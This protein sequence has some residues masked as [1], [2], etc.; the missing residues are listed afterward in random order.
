MSQKARRRL[1]E[2]PAEALVPFET[3]Q[4]GDA[5]ATLLETGRLGGGLAYGDRDETWRGAYDWM[6]ERMA[7]AIA[8]FSGEYPVWGWPRAIR[9]TSRELRWKEGLWRIRALVPRGRLLP[10][11][12]ALWHHPLNGWSIDRDEDAMA[13][14]WHAPPAAKMETWGAVLQI[15]GRDPELAAFLGEP[16]IVQLCLDGLLLDEVYDT[17]PISRFRR[18]VPG[19]R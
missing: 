10:S 14:N 2:A 8:G 15:A 17:V 13:R 4:D 7:G 16:E 3:Y 18:P 1:Q 9:L 11:C 6:R 19:P 12:F 5:V